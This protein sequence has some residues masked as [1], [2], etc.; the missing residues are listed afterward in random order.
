MLSTRHAAAWFGA[1]ALV[2]LAA[3]A[4]PFTV[5]D[6]FIVVRY[7]D[8]LA[9]GQGYTFSGSTP[10]DGV[11][12]P[13]WLLPLVVGAWLG[14]DPLSVA[15]TCSLAACV[16]S[17]WAVSAR[18][19]SAVLG[20]HSVWLALVVA[21]SSLPF[22]VWSVAGL[23]TGLAAYCA[24]LLALAATR[25]PHADGTLVGLSLAALAWLRPELLAFGSCLL[26]LLGLRQGERRAARRA[27]AIGLTGIVL[28]LGFRYF[29]FG[30][31]LPMSASAKPAL[32]GHG[33]SYLLDGLLRA[34]VWVLVLLLGC[35]LRFGGQ[36]SQTLLAGLLVH[37][38]A[39]VLVGGDWMPGRRL[40][41]P[42]VPVLALTLA[43][44]TRVLFARRPHVGWAMS[45]ALLA[46]SALEL[47]PE[48]SAVRDAGALR[49]QRAPQ[50]ARLICAATGP[51]ALLD[52]G[53]L[54]AACPG[55]SFVDLG[56][57]TEPA[58]AYARGAHLDK[59]IDPHWLTARAPGLVVLHS[60]ERPS[61][62]AARQL[63]WFAGYPV[64]R[65]VLA[66]PFMRTYEVRHVFAYAPHYDYVLLTPRAA[67]AAAA[68]SVKR[69]L[70][71]P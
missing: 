48:L 52:V 70:N 15:K 40:F 47:L 60:G 7:A 67:P 71:A 41:A 10:S 31:L 8:R 28:V 49:Q 29:M 57:L 2:A 32:I 11:T 23:E 68:G 17:W 1:F 50:L 26:F 43:L 64:E 20:R 38:L 24:T 42:L 9:R 19:R 63:R 4:W 69:A 37:A 36:G 65:R 27:W 34:R 16:L 58:I 3:A 22:V 62:D 61:V 13:L 53:V 12:G 45:V 35:A 66:M 33:L 30:H 21:T 25:R 51:V 5:D 55:Q 56:G 39:V 14:L 44:G 6:A 46:A 18:L 59:Q 54:A